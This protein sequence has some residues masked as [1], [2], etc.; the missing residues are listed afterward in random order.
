MTENGT[1]SQTIHEGIATI[2][3]GHPRSNSLPGALLREIAS[4]IDAAGND[5]AVRVVVLKTLGEKVFCGGASFDELLAVKTQQESE[6]F[7]SGFAT[8]ISAMRRCP[9]FIV[10]RVQGKVVGGGVGIVAASD[11]VFAVT[12]AALR[13]SEFA[14]GFGPFV[15]GPAVQRKVGTAA[16]SQIAVDADWRDATWGHAHGLYAQL[17][18]ELSELDSAVTKFATKL[19][20]ANPEATAK[21]KAVLWEGTEDWDALLRQRVAITSGLALTDFVQRAVHAV[22]KG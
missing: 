2:I 1:V 17:F 21:L 4:T 5:P 3:F 18:S 20:A 11:Y 13:L 7:F 14:L 9:K 8:V 12:G 22:N 10:T 15:I 6:R 16:F 19:S